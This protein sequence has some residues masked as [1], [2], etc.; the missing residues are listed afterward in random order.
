M[1]PDLNWSCYDFTWNSYTSDEEWWEPTTTNWALTTQERERERKREREFV[2]SGTLGGSAVRGCKSSWGP[3]LWSRWS[4]MFSAGVG[5]LKNL[6]TPQPCWGRQCEG[7]EGVKTLPSLWKQPL[8][9]TR[10]CFNLKFRKFKLSFLECLWLIGLSSGGL[11]GGGGTV[12]RGPKCSA[13][14]GTVA[15]EAS[16][17][18]KRGIEVHCL[19]A[20]LKYIYIIY[21][22]YIVYILYT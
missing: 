12:R 8:K 17:V 5:I 19:I 10:L 11:T 14:R 3:G 9:H 4:R 21:K 18:A 7:N 20:T 6:P 22:V 16:S 1:W 15:G 13:I 2:L